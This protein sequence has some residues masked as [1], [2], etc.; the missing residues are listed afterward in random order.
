MAVPITQYVL[1]IHSRCN[2]ACDHCY[3]YEHPD[4]SWRTQ[5]L[6][7]S[8][9][10]TVMAAKRISEHAADHQVPR[11]SVVLHGG[12]PLLLGRSRMR[13]LLAE[14]QAR[15]GAVTSLDLRIQTNGVLLDKHWCNLFREFQV[16]VG[17]SVDGDRKANDR[18]RNHADGSSSYDQALD[19]L[20]LLRRP[21]YQHL[22]AGILCT[23]DLANDPVAVYRALTA[24]EPPN[25]DLLLPHATWDRPPYRPD[26]QLTPYADWLLRIYRCWDRDGRPVPIRLFDSLL[27]AARGGSSFTESLGTDPGDL[28]V[29]ETNG[30]WEQPD[31]MKTAFD[32]AAATGMNVFDHPV[33]AVSAHPGIAARQ[34]GADAL[35]ATCRG[36]HVVRVCGGGLYA[37]RYRGDKRRG[38]LATET[39]E[40]ENPSVYCADLMTLIDAVLARENRKAA[41]LAVKPG[42]ARPG[43]A[44]RAA[45]TGGTAAD[46][47]EPA[48]PAEPAGPAGPAGPDRGDIPAGVIDSLAKGPGDPA[49]VARLAAVRLYEATALTAAVADSMV[50]WRDAS[51]RRAAAEGW[52][53]LGEL[54]RDHAQAVD[55]VFA[56]PFTYAWALRCL[57]PQAGDDDDLN[58][59]HLASLALAAAVRAGVPATLPAPV[60][61]GLAYLPTLGAIAVDR[62]SGRTETV[63]V[64][65]GR[66]P[67]GG[68]DGRWQRTRAMTGQ[69]F[70]G[71]A[72]E[73]LDPF[74]DCREWTVQGRLAAP[75]W[76][77]WHRSLAAAGRYLDATIPGYAPVLA[78]W[79]RSV[80]P[81]PPAA[82]GRRSATAWQ[83]FGAVAIS[84]PAAVAGASQLAE[85][86]LRDFQ[87]AKLSVLTDARTLFDAE[88]DIRVPA[89][90]RDD[91][92]PVVTAVSETY[93]FLALAHLWHAQGA[94]GRGAYHRYRRR[95]DAGLS[96]L[97][98]VS[99]ALTPDGLRFVS[100]MAEAVESMTR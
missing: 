84:R 78:A 56:H 26:G 10:V 39:A 8:P 89:P 100:G 4:Q 38:T 21:E 87:H 90:G 99:G 85:V 49:D 51:L 42:S 30:D 14:L 34:G 93:G 73:D 36:C 17:V 18:H 23:V 12:E 91:P 92:C 19:A 16:K 60:R 62:G 64:T 53:L 20:R 77:R 52:A 25:L 57:R 50:G 54:R 2:L 46:P 97:L 5:P 81:L 76:E 66:P 15:V 48:E 11:I 3:V 82:D 58:R 63:T 79:L 94:S 37:H 67:A 1:K 7:I 27:S 13:R 98:A 96:G 24:Q 88:A 95:V 80:I 33:D 40:F 47:A 55:Q 32:G 61:D 70:P 35:S 68:G 86:L 71:L 6:T 41:R 65:P 69:P 83:A 43:A 45:E 29:I 59:A 28:L 31:S 22:Y 72:V 44:E 9:D 75:E 74:R